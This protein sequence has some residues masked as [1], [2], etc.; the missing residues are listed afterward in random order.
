MA[1]NKKS[2]EDFALDVPS[3]DN[4]TE[5]EAERMITHY[6][7][8]D[9][10]NEIEEQNPYLDLFSSGWSKR[11]NYLASANED[12]ILSRLKRSKRRPL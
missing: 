2:V 3:F 7:Q 6:S 9:S 10:L 12:E 1:K 5:R 8:Y 11:A 4:D